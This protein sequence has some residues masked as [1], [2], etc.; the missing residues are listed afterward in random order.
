M[1]SPKSFSLKFDMV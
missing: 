1:H